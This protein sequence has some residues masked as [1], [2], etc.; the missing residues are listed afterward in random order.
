MAQEH[1]KL[2]KMFAALEASLPAMIAMH[3][4]GA[5]FWA[6]FDKQADEIE[7]SAGR[8]EIERVRHRLVALLAAHDLPSP[9]QR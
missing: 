7:D 6:A 9:A 5:D 1:Y 2:E 4:D 8:S 3:P